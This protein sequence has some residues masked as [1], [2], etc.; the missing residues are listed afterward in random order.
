MWTLQDHFRTRCFILF[1]FLVID[2]HSKWPEIV[3]MKS[4][5]VDDTIVVRRCIFA[6]FGLPDQL[7]SNNGP[8]F[9]AREFANFVNANGI[10][11]IRT[12]PYYPASNG[13]IE[14]FVQTFKQAMKAGEG[15]GLSFQHQLHNFLMSHRSTPHTTTGKSPA[16]LFLGRPLR[17]RFDLLC[18]VVGEK[19][20]REQ[21]RQ[22]Q[23]HDTVTRF[24]QFAVG[25]RVMVR[26]GRGKSVWKPG[27]IVER[28]GPVS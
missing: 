10:P 12:A 26:E 22:K 1:L 8:Q 23:H 19:L 18:P 17:T 27:T 21:A 20:C 15:N 16:S 6:S 2:A 24:S 4:T 13:T 5:T 9:T 28:Q 3:E 25:A 14:R 7:V 11:H